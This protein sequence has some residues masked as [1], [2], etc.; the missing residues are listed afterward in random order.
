MQITINN[1]PFECSEG[2]SVATI[3]A[4]AGLPTTGIAVAV[5]TQ[6]VP[7]TEWENTKV[8]SGAKIIIIKAVQG[9]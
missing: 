5:G 2:D 6:I 4:L 3:L 7:R 1:K 9:G 8:Q